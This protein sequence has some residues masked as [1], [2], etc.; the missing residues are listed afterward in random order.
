M[1][2]LSIIELNLSQGLNWPIVGGWGDL[3]MQSE[4]L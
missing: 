1:Q 2:L 4:G 3:I